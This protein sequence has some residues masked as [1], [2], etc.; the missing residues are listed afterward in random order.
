MCL[1]SIVMTHIQRYILHVFFHVAQSMDINI[2]Q[3]YD[4]IDPFIIYCI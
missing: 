2:E 3:Y 4:I 1:E